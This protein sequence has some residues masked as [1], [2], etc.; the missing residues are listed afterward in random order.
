MFFSF[1]SFPLLYSLLFPELLLQPPEGNSNPATL[2]SKVDVAR[3]FLSA[4][5]V[6]TQRICGPDVFSPRNPHVPVT[7]V[8][9]VQVSSV[10]QHHI[11]IMVNLSTYTTTCMARLLQ[12]KSKYKDLFHGWVDLQNLTSQTQH[13]GCMSLAIMGQSPCMFA[14]PAPSFKPLNLLLYLSPVFHTAF[15]LVSL[16][17]SVIEDKGIL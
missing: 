2:E 16:T 17:S 7:A 12:K 8:T 11:E 15:S 5:A 4:G 1:L 3:Q 13:L 14:K 6:R 10:M 9:H